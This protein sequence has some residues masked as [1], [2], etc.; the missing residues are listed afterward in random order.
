MQKFLLIISILFFPSLLMAQFNNYWSRNF[1]EESSLLSGAVVGGGAGASAIYYNPA[2]ISEITESKLSL[3]A[4]LFSFDFMNAK[5]ALGEGIDFE[6]SRSFVVPRFFSYMIKPKKHPKWSLEVAFLN[7]ANNEIEGSNY[8]DK[9]IDIL[10]HTPGVERYTAYSNIYH[11]YRDDWLGLGGSYKLSDQLFL[12]VSM[13]VSFKSEYY[14]YSLDIDASSEA[15]NNDPFFA[16]DYTEYDLL[17]Y[18]DYRMLWK[19]GLIYKREHLSFGVNI[20][21]PSIGNIY[22]DGKRVMRK[23]SQNNITD[24]ESG[25]AIPNYLLTDFN[26]NKN[27]TINSKSPFSIA[28]GLTFY[29]EGNTKAIFTTIEYFAGIEPY[30][31]AHA[32][33]NTSAVKGTF[34]QE[35]GNWLTFSNGAKPVLNVAIGYRWKTKKDYTFLTGFRTDFNYKKDVDINPYLMNKSINGF[36]TDNYH[37]TGGMSVKLLGQDLIAGIQYT[38]GRYKNQT[39]FANLSDP[40]EFESSELKALQGPRLNTMNSLFNSFSIY[41]GATINFAKARQE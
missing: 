3:N 35:Y 39:Q 34:E 23:R 8:V 31:L 18:N 37:F 25:E 17:K 13:F 24:P 11:K 6:D 36:E 5:N 14:T 38:F 30:D 19:M 9:N 26:E 12:G 41:F 4:S 27:L 29:N 32:P 15:P 10:T 16:A 33:V 1:N 2:S 20:T 22:S 7:V 28:G 21:T 40:V